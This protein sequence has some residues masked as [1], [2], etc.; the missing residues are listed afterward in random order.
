MKR[1][2]ILLLVVFFVPVL[3]YGQ[4]SVL[5]PLILHALQSS[6]AE[7]L[8]YYG[9]MVANGVKQLEFIEKQ[10]KA[11]GKSL[12]MAYRNLLT[13][14]D[15]KSFDDFMDWNNRQIALEKRFEDSIMNYRVNIGGKNYA[16][17]A[18]IESA[19]Y[20]LKDTY[21]DY[22]DREFT[23]EQRKE[24]WLSL[25]LTPSNYAYVKTWEKREQE[26]AHDFLVY[27]QVQQEERALRH[28]RHSEM[29]SALANDS[30]NDED[31]KISDKELAAM[32]VD[33]LVDISTGIDEMIGMQA[34]V[35]EWEAV[36]NYQ[37][38]TPSDA[39]ALSKWP[40]DAFGRSDT[41]EE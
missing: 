2:L 22:W 28:N 30:L 40:T 10:S 33:V 7:D 18:D 36:K 4:V 19:A 11:M 25:G 20:G 9:Q 21:V 39:P 35:M 32:Q 29:L 38:R 6:G 24:M 5:E 14:G 17:I 15:I 27:H 41:I 23:E 13:A 12:E 8:I 26:L 1:L 34:Q 3:S 31:N 16:V 37:S